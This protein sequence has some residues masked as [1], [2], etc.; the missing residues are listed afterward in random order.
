MSLSRWSVRDGVYIR[1]KQRLLR[2]HSDGSLSTPE[3]V[4]CWICGATERTGGEEELLTN[5]LF[6]FRIFFFTALLQILLPRFLTPPHTPS[7]S[8]FFFFH[9]PVKGNKSSCSSVILRS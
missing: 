3:V 1:L 6:I 2:L 9:S 5:Y 4:F 7:L 8:L